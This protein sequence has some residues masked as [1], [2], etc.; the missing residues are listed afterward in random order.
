MKPPIITLTT[1]FGLQD[2]YTGTMKGVILSRC[3][4]AP[5]VDITHHIPPFSLYA[6]AYAISQAA[7]FFPSGTI[8][9]V[10]V[11]P[12]VGTAR[13]PLLVEFERQFFIAPDNGVL[14]LRLSHDAAF[15]AREITNR[16]LWL[17]NPSNTFHGRDIF[18]PSA[19]ALANGSASPQDLG[20]LLDRIERLPDLEPMETEPGISRGKVLSIDHFGNVITN[21]RPPTAAFSLRIGPHHI[22]DLRQSF[23]GA[24]PDL[25]FAYP[26][27]SGYLEVARNGRSAAQA[28]GV[29]S[30]DAVTLHLRDTIGES[31][32]VLS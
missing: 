27:S 24:P 23:D 30:G 6:G 4:G 10:V 32:K 11:D 14:S 18:A 13:K 5:I 25:L 2:H 3:P 16:E 22:R 26:G 29:S 19:A 9:V 12:G 20:P 1:D 31:R 8:H 28:L 21:F 15:T 17:P 7:P